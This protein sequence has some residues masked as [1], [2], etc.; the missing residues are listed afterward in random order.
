MEALYPSVTTLAALEGWALTAGAVAFMALLGGAF[1]LVLYFASRRFRVATDPRIDRIL[2]ALPGVNCGACGFG[3]CRAYAE[4]LVAGKSELGVCAPGGPEA[5]GKAAE[6]LGVEAAE[7][8]AR[9]AVIHCAGSPDLAPAR[10]SYLGIEDC[11]A[12]VIAGAG[13]GPKACEYG[14]L[15]LGTCVEACPFDAMFTGEGGLPHVVKSLCTGCGACVKSC[16]LGIIRLHP[17]SRDVFVLCSS[18]LSAR[19][20]RGVCQIGCI[21]CKRC[22]KVC[23]AEAIVME[24]NLAVIDDSKCTGCGEC[25]AACPRGT[26]WP[27]GKPVE[28]AAAS[29]EGA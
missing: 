22:V 7:V 3:G 1:G 20:V 24:D 15:G 14:C 6:V 18:K 16:P 4:S 26:I 2:D 21:A 10:G 11:R 25:V 28:V 5:A 9:V 17:K 29:G 8:E 23:S 12:A 27:L 13:G 19:A